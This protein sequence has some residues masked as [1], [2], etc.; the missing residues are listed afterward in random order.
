MSYSKRKKRDNNKLKKIKKKKI[1]KL[2]S[3]FLY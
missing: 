3:N 1:E 2:K